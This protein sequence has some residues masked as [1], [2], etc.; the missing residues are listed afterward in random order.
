MVGAPIAT[1]LARRNYIVMVIDAFY[2]GERRIDLKDIAPSA[3][4]A[5]LSVVPPRGSA[6]HR[7][8]EEYGLFE[9][10]V[11]RHLFAA[12]TAWMGLMVHDDRRSIDYLLT[13]PEV[14]PDKIGCIGN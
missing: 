3:A 1:E 2:F 5:L 11:A 8:N 4:Q 9:E 6:I 12:G 10:V 14:N 7:A 13:R